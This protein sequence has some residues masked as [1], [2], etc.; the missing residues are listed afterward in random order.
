MPELGVRSTFS[1]SPFQLL[2]NDNAGLIST[3]TGFFYEHLNE[4]YL[5][6]NWHNISGR[7][8]LTNEPLSSRLPTFIEAKFYKKIDEAG[9][10]TTVAERIEI[11]N[12][13]L[14]LWYE[15]PKLKSKC[16]VVAIKMRRPDF[17]AEN[18]NFAANIISKIR[19][20]IKPGNTV[21]VIG[22]PKSI[23]VGFG[24]PLWKSGYIASEPFYDV[25]IGGEVSPIGGLTNGISLPAFFI[26]TQSRE[27]MSGSPVFAN[28][29]GNWN[30]KHPYEEVNPDAPDFLINRDI[31]LGE[32][33][34]EFIGCYSARI[35]TNEEGAALGLC[36]R[37]S[38]I[39]EICVGNF[40]GQH[41]QIS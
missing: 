21:F 31:A 23:S 1:Q 8:F 19:I 26:D 29:I 24:L 15:H 9:S 18:M 20:P 3:G 10:F 6:T 5:I 13:Q 30:T 38:T 14:P 37:S 34:M 17:I 22:F 7:H 33:R 4:H 35:G 27:G 39:D 40:I 32:N 16:D 36:W 12:N 28:Y 25:T 11:Y 41:P 2:M